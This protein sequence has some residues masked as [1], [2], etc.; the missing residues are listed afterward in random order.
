MEIVLTPGNNK[1]INLEG[2]TTMQRGSAGLITTA[3]LL[4]LHLQMLRN[5]MVCHPCVNRVEPDI[6][7][8][9][10]AHLKIGSI[11]GYV[12]LE[13]KICLSALSSTRLLQYCDLAAAVAE[14]LDSVAKLMDKF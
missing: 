14:I 10:F 7:C 6:P 1:I 12:F 3:A 5:S 8:A 9:G 2:R 11:Q 13:G 4:C